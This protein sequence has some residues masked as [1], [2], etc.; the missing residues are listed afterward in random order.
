MKSAAEKFEICYLHIGPPKTGS[1]SIQSALFGNRDRLKVLGYLYP[2]LAANHVFLASAFHSKPEHIFLH[3]RQGRTTRAE[4]KAHTRDQMARFEAEMQ[5]ALQAGA[6]RLVLSN[7]NLAGLGK[8]DCCGLATYLR[9]HAKA[10]QVICYVRHPL[11]QV[12]SQAQQRVKVGQCTLEAALAHPPVAHLDRV[13]DAY[14]AAFGK[15]AIRLTDFSRSRLVGGDVVED[16]LDRIGVVVGQRTEFSRT[17]KNK[18]LSHEALLLADAAARLLPREVDGKWNPARSQAL[19]AHLMGIRGSRLKPSLELC[20]RI[21]RPATRILAY[22]EREFAMVPE[23]PDLSPPGTEDLWQGRT[24]EDLILKINSL[25]L[26]NQRLRGQ[27]GV[28]RQ[29]AQTAAGAQKGRGF[30]RRVLGRLRR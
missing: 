30:L 12:L 9:G 8:G 28:L 3:K 26:E 21:E 4:I 25:S 16:F 23:P 24:L 17:A 6:Q 7:E 10:V 13:L 22:L 14:G 11:A 5:Q 15:D 19:E 20:D 29:Q 27:I 18:S 1:S 2:S